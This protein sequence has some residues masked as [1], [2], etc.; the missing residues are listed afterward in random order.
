MRR[1]VNLAHRFSERARAKRAQ[2]F[3]ESFY[4]TE[5]TRI[6]DLGSASGENIHRVLHDTN[7]RP[8]NVYIADIHPQQVEKGAIDFGYTPVI[9]K[10]MESLPFEDNFFDI[11][12][13]SS[14]IEHVTVPK[15]QVWNMKSGKRFRDLA[16]Q[17]QFRFS[18]DIRRLGRQYFVQTPNRLFPIES[19][20]W[21][22]FFSFLPRRLMVPL[23]RITNRF[24]IKQTIPDWYLLREK[25]MNTL[26]KGA[27]IVHEKS[28]GMTKSFMAI[29]SE[30]LKEKKTDTP[31]ELVY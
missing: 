31:N 22:P 13:C 16:F 1:I 12:Y 9:I 3:K 21:F 8:E 5:D 11:V 30:R 10:E 19:H 24:W 27:K 25:D 28:C 29:S 4:L 15:K 7:V 18:S 14:V 26:F 6:L 17:S 23:L 2:V 20:S